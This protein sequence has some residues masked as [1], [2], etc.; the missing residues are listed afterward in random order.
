M[1]KQGD[2]VYVDSVFIKGKGTVFY[3]EHGTF[4]PIAVLLDEPPFE[5]GH[6]LYRFETYEVKKIE[7]D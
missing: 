1:V 2:R 6:T 7:E 5:D 3:V 4:Y